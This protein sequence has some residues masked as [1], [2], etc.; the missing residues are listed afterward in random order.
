[1][2]ALFSRAP[3]A[4]PPPCAREQVN[5]EVEALSGSGESSMGKRLASHAPRPARTGSEKRCLLAPRLPLACL[6]APACALSLSHGHVCM[7]IMP[8]GT[9]AREP[10]HSTST[11]G[12]SLLSPGPPLIP[13]CASFDVSGAA[14]AMCCEFGNALGLYGHLLLEIH[15][16][17]CGEL[18]RSAAF[19]VEAA[20]R[21]GCSFLLLRCRPLVCGMGAGLSVPPG[22]GAAVTRRGR[23]ELHHPQLV[24]PRAASAC[25]AVRLKR[26]AERAA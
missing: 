21:A 23:R 12:A 5:S 16:M 24:R 1:M 18:L 10:D 13:A 3:A 25:A 6:E 14:S 26:V 2:G 8:T 17:V 20:R 4:V 15:T 9:T 22:R 11:G 19:V 7:L